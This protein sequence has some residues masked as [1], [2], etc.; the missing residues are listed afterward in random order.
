MN[1]IGKVYCVTNKINGKQ[2]FGCAIESFTFETVFTGTPKQ[3]LKKERWFIKKFNTK[4]PNGYNQT[5]GGEAYMLDK[6]HT[7]E[8]LAKMSRTRKGRHNPMWGKKLSSEAR[9]KLSISMTERMRNPEVLA[10]LKGNKYGQGR[11]NTLEHRAKL[12]EA[13]KRRIWTPEARAKLSISM[14]ERMRNPEVR[15][16]IGVANKGRITRQNEPSP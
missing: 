9:E 15:A 2:Y 4:A 14:T 3:A 1:K 13:N 11:I 12:G 7:S 8:A 16:N 6:K 10:K 5:N